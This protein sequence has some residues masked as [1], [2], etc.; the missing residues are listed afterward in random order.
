MADETTAMVQM[1]SLTMN[2]AEKCIRGSAA[3]IKVLAKVFWQIY[4]KLKQ[5]I[6][7]LPGE[8]T[9]MRF[10]L[11]GKSL[12]CVTMNKEQF[13]LFKK[14]SNRYHIQYHH[15]NNKKGKNNDLVTVFIPES[16]A[17]KFNKLV[18]D[19]KLNS[20]ENLGTVQAE[21]VHPFKKP[22]M[23]TILA[24]NIDKEGNID[25]FEIRNNLIKAGMDPDEADIFVDDFLDSKEF[26]NSEVK[27][28]ISGISLE[29]SKEQT[30]EAETSEF[31]APAEEIT[32]NYVVFDAKPP[33]LSNRDWS[34]DRVKLE[35]RKNDITSSIKSTDEPAVSE[36][37]MQE[38]SNINQ[39]I[40]HGDKGNFGAIENDAELSSK[41]ISYVGADAT[42]IPNVAEDAAVVST[43]V[44]AAESGFSD[45]VEDIIDT[46]PITG[47]MEG[48]HGTTN[49]SAF[50]SDPSKIGKIDTKGVDVD[51]NP[52]IPS[53]APGL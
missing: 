49:Y 50:V 12:Q 39:I 35:E 18:S 44:P 33:V 40:E 19:L 20:I 47:G 24:E 37:K 29:A 51:I 31:M 27:V 11:D 9:M 10:A 2:G 28:N 21:D 17:H 14:N 38:I 13:D 36:F 16:D 3:V 22:D 46:K 43:E 25:L 15:I 34:Q 52:N 45:T 32:E 53:S 42:D 7:L 23:S 48:G 30:K 5:R 8:R 6:D 4:L 26:K 41:F 1:L